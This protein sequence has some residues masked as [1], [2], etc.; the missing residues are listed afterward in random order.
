DLL[1]APAVGILLTFFVEVKKHGRTRHGT[2]ARFDLESAF[3]VADPAPGVLLACLAR[4]HFH[5]V[6]NHEG[7]VKT[8][9]ELPDQVG[10]FLSIPGE[11]SEEVLGPGTGNRAQMRDQ[12]LLIHAYT[13]IADRQRLLF[14]IKFQIDS[15]VEGKG[16]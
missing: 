1:Q 16:L 12:L 5:L 15:R 7:A 10:I 14:L 6:R 8:Y 3:A 13:G 11:L 2:L 4:R 9:A